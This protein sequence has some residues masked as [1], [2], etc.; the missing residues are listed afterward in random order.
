MG[1][2]LEQPARSAGWRPAARNTRRGG[3]TLVEVLITIVLLG[4]ATALVIPSMSQT[5]VLR[6]QSA[7]RQTVSD[8]M[9]AQTD[10]M[11]YQQ[12]RAIWFNR[13]WTGSDSPWT[14]DVGNGYTVAEVRDGTLDLAVHA[15][16][17]PETNGDPYAVTFVGR[18]YGGARID[19][20]D[21][22]GDEVLIFD[23]LGG[24]V[25]DLSGETP[26]AG[27]AIE[28]VGGENDEWQYRIS[29]APMTGRVTV[30]TLDP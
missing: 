25:A 18:D 2:R 1:A 4:L 17:N 13:T 5:G 29:V 30:E 26:S 9:F 15:L 24:P 8:I 12:P 14:F 6:V 27:G 19:S 21:F 20:A 16:V 10:A 22:D 23:E 3:F 11:A 7:V 28:I